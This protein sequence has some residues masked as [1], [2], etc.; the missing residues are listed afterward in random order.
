MQHQFSV[1]FD[2]I[3]NSKESIEDFIDKIR[4]VLISNTHNIVESSLEDIEYMGSREKD[5]QPFTMKDW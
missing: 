2:V 4:F 5:D 1:S 3:I